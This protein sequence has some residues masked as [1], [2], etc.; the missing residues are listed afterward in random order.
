MLNNILISNQKTKDGYIILLKN[1]VKKNK[2]F[3]KICCII[4]N[5]I[6]GGNYIVKIIGN[7]PSY[8]LKNNQKYC[9]S[10]KMLVKTDNITWNHYLEYLNCNIQKNDYQ[11]E[12]NISLN[13]EESYSDEIINRENDSLNKSE[14][15]F[16]NFNI[17]SEIKGLNKSF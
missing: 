16:I 3:L 1:K 17:D 11:E 8:K 13:S 9:V 6:D 4:E 15:K 12:L 10:N 14:F 5:Y 2:S 7:Y